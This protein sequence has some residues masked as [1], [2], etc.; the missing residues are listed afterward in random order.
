[1]AEYAYLIVGVVA[2]VGALVLV[3]VVQARRNAAG[4]PKHSW[5]S[6]LL[7]W[8]LLLDAD[9]SKRGGRVLTRREWLGWG[10]V[11]LVMAL[12]IVFAP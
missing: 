3:Y 1:M 9:Q 8:P 12:A 7:L 5:I 10:L 2:G 11:I 4:N 6:Y